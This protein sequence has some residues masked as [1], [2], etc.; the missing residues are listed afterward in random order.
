MND[1]KEFVIPFSGL[2]LGIHTFD[3]EINRKFF[4]S[5]EYSEIHDGEIS[6]HVELNKQNNMLIFNFSFSGKVNV[7]CDRCAD[8]F[9]MPIEGNNRLIVKFGNIAYEETEEI[10]VLTETEHEIDLAPFIYEYLILAMPLK[11][12]H[13]DDENG[14]SQCDP[15]VIK[16]LEEISIRHKD[17]NDID[18]RWDA[19]KNLN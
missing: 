19:L 4:E 17:N 7:T 8:D 3:F 11:R 1:M 13:P 16:K 5:I 10:I 14:V 2:S 12:V 6:W 15:E 9:D 18:P